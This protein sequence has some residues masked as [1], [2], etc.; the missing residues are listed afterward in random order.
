MSE[1]RF[2]VSPAE[3]TAGAGGVARVEGDEHHHLSR[4]LR[5]SVPDEIW[6]FDGEGIGWS[7]IIDTIE[8]DRTLVRL[9]AA[10]RRPVEPALHLTLAQGVPHHDR[11]DLAVQK[12]TEVGVGRIVPILTERSVMRPRDDAGWKRLER[13]RRV[14]RDAARQSGRLRVPEV[15]EPLSW[16]S[17]LASQ[18]AG[19][20]PR[21]I[22]STQPGTP[23]LARHPIGA[24]P[25][26]AIVAVGPEGG[27]TP[28]EID[29]AIA[30]GYVAAGLGPRILRAETAAIA[31]VA[32]ILHQAGE[33]GR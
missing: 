5:L 17:W 23:P 33:L 30:A 27:F 20:G 31:A 9:V 28:E 25:A 29:L 32:L 26:S 4:V 21:W 19:P 18:A 22:L 10:D 7:G 15:A 3:L 1:R 24:G 11:M 14:A 2:L 12:C 6:L 13:W 8:R 16:D